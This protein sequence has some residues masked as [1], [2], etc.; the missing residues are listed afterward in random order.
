MLSWDSGPALRTQDVLR[1]RGIVASTTLSYL[2]YWSL[3][4]EAVSSTDVLRIGVSS[5]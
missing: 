5:S 1:Y 4:R 2:E 3:L